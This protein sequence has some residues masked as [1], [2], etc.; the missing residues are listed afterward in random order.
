MI[1]VID[2]IKK[3]AWPYLAALV[4]FA[5]WVWVAGGPASEPVTQWAMVFAAFVLA[6]TIL[7]GVLYM[8]DDRR[9]LQMMKFEIERPLL[10]LETEWVT[11]PDGRRRLATFLVNLG[12]TTACEIRVAS[13]LCR[14][15]DGNR[16]ARR[17]EKTDCLV[18]HAF[19]SHFD[20]VAPASFSEGPRK[21]CLLECDEEQE[22]YSPL[23]D[24]GAR[25]VVSYRDCWGFWYATVLERGTQHWFSLR[26][27][28]TD[29]SII[30][31]LLRSAEL[32]QSP[33]V[34]GTR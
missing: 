10:A 4:L 34:C 7:S 6:A 27:M 18:R 24:A 26:T 11:S 12:K 22:F 31:L 32:F 3:I 13:D 1:E 30:E 23:S 2:T 9:M 20:L 14:T 28:P 29:P 5:C 21:A 33:D 19:G 25:M 15:D 8:I 17:I 16:G